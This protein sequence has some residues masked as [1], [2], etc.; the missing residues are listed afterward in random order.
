[1][2]T[3]KCP[4]CHIT[5]EDGGL[6]ATMMDLYGYCFDCRVNWN[7]KTKGSVRP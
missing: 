4:I 3:T 7:D 1:M 6:D 2:M 5:I